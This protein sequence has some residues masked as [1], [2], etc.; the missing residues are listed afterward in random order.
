[1]DDFEKR[2][3]RIQDML[4][5]EARGD[6]PPV[7]CSQ[8]TLFGIPSRVEQVMDAIAREDEEKHRAEREATR[9]AARQPAAR[10][11]ADR[12]SMD[13]QEADRE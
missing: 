1:M 9:Q 2:W 7:V 11:T 6:R 10:Q 3:K 4:G 5:V 13:H 12:Q 8:R